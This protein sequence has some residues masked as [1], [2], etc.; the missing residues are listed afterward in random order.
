LPSSFSDDPATGFNR[1]EARLILRLER[2]P[3]PANAVAV[4]TMIGALAAR[5]FIARWVSHCHRDAA[6]TSLIFEIGQGC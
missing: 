3:R 2:A 1:C 5:G 6:V 4:R